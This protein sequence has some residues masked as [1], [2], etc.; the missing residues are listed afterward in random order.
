MILASKGKEKLMVDEAEGNIATVM[1]VAT[2]DSAETIL[3][4]VYTMITMSL[5]H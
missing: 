4:L 5:W 2:A 3:M 1:T